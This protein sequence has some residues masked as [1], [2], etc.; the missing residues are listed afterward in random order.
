MNRWSSLLQILLFLLTLVFLIKRCHWNYGLV[1]PSPW[2]SPLTEAHCIIYQSDSMSLIMIRCDMMVWNQ[3]NRWGKSNKTCS[4]T[5]FFAER[6]SS[7]VQTSYARARLNDYVCY[8]TW[9]IFELDFVTV[10]CS[11]LD[12]LVL[13]TANIISLFWQWIQRNGGVHV[14]LRSW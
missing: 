4:T 14:C 2:A 3:W 12:L 10:A 7:E 13:E 6:Y 9:Q 1:S 8:F 11:I 5:F